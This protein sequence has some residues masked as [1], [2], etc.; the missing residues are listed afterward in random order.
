MQLSW[1]VPVWS[2]NMVR[3]CEGSLG[4]V[5]SGKDGCKVGE[6]GEKWKRIAFGDVFRLYL[7]EYVTKWTGE[8]IEMDLEVV[9]M[10][11][12]FG[13]NL[14]FVQ[15]NRLWGSISRISQWALIQI[16][17]GLKN[18]IE[19]SGPHLLTNFGEFEIWIDFLDLHMFK[20]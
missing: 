18:W 5:R 4:A 12:F 2:D 1:M 8:G 11:W 15:K 13:R 16:E 6:K 20:V 10:F 19:E 14:K 17:F 3:V 9:C 7:N